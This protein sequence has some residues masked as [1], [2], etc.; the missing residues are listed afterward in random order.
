MPDDILVLELGV[1]CVEDTEPGSLTWT[2]T[3]GVGG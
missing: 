3:L 1:V 2:S